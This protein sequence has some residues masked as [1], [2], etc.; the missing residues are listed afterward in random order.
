[1]EKT[2]ISVPNKQMVDTIVDNISLRTQRKAELK[3]EIDINAS[4]QSIHNLLSV[5][6][7]RL[8]QPFVQ[9]PKVYL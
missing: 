7:E 4:S 6:K 5:I 3:I 9:S 8:I 2:F 1:M